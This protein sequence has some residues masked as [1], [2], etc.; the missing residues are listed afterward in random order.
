M[1]RSPPAIRQDVNTELS[2]AF[3]EIRTLLFSV[4]IRLPYTQKKSSAA[5]LTIEIGTIAEDC[6][7]GHSHQ[8][9]ACIGKSYR[10]IPQCLCFGILRL[11]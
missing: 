2:C 9:E 10:E 3:A 7:D 6:K 1:V 4:K 5:V 8:R 11:F